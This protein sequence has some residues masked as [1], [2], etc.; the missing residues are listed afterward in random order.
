MCI[1]LF[2]STI[3]HEVYDEVGEAR[4][5]L[6]A[7]KGE[8]ASIG[9]LLKLPVIQNSE[10]IDTQ[11]GHKKIDEYFGTNIAGAYTKE[12]KASD[13]HNSMT[14]G[15]IPT[16]G[17]GL[18]SLNIRKL[19]K[20]GAIHDRGGLTKSG[21]SLMK[22]GYREGSVFPKPVGNPAQVNVKGQ[23][24]LEEILNDP[25]NKVYR[26]S[27]GILKVYSPNGRGAAFRKDGTFKGFI[28]WQYE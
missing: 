15:V 14:I 18:K 6:N 19:A 9:S 20:A 3:A 12:G 13:P 11:S 7:L 22:H 23:M 24:I 28:E 8:I 25:K 16:P 10:Q 21:R 17:S 27:D 5:L 2:A 4:E 26:F 1:K